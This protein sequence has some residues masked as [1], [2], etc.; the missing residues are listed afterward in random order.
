MAS[1]TPA[2]IKKSPTFLISE[3][4]NQGVKI[5]LGRRRPRCEFPEQWRGSWFQSGENT[6]IAING[7]RISNKGQCT[8]A[9]G[10]MFLIYD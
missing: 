8:E 6:L 3:T 2:S 5:C 4:I 10:D 7:T 9:D 1:T